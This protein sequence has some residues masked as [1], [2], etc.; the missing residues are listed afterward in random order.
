[1]ELLV[2]QSKNYQYHF[3]FINLKDENEK[4]ADKNERLIFQETLS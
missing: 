1:M 2:S 4:K 3:S